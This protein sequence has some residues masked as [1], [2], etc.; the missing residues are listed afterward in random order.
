VVTTN[1]AEERAIETAAMAV[2]G[3]T[4]EGEVW[5]EVQEETYQTLA[6]ALSGRIMGR[7]GSEVTAS[8]HM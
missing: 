2:A 4:A 6:Y 3:V 1:L 8:F 7:V 5:E